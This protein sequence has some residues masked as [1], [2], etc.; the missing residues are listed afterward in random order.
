[1]NPAEPPP[2][3]AP[4][5][6]P[7]RAPSPLESVRDIWR[8]GEKLV[9]GYKLYGLGHGNTRV[10]VSD[11]HGKLSAWFASRGALEV[12]LTPT[13]VLI[14]GEKVFR[15]EGGEHNWAQPL[16]V[17][18]VVRLRLEPGLDPVELE[19]LFSLLLPKAVGAG[20]ELTTRLWT[21]SFAHVHWKLDSELDR[22]D[23][24][25]EAT[26]N[27]LRAALQLVQAGKAE[28]VERTPKR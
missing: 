28:T 15:G 11:L 3:P 20:D 16:A 14:D 19:R 7:A 26:A 24:R 27:W 6:A 22:A 4:Q 25:D 8:A 10:F 23:P 2:E 9:R 18:G 5:P 12:T 17:S 1:M 21:E 13:D